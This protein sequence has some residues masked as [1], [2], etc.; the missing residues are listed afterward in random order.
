MQTDV[1]IN[2]DMY[3]VP[4]NI[5]AILLACACSLSPK[6]YILAIQNV[7]R[8]LWQLCSFNILEGLNLIIF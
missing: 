5:S 4:T 6:L 2:L 1:F 7:A 3:V 8:L